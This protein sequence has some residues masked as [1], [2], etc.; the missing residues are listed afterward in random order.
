[1]IDR[2]TF[3]RP[4]DRRRERVPL[5]EFGDDAA[6]WVYGWTAGERTAWEKEFQKPNGKPDKVR[7]NEIRER[8]VVRCVRDDN[9]Q[10]IFSDGDLEAIRQQDAAVIERVVNAALRVT[11]VTEGDIEELVGNSEETTHS[12]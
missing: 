2:E 4:L 8:L 6:C 7:Q 3:L 1:M 10:P 11:G 9:G 12:D 5:P